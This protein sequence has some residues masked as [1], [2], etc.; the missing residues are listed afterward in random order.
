MYKT[1]T[2]NL[3]AMEK[4]RWNFYNVFH[5]QLADTMNFSTKNLVSNVNTSECS[6]LRIR[7]AF[8]L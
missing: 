4:E 2:N 6:Q 1:E 5:F 3:F 7:T 8:W